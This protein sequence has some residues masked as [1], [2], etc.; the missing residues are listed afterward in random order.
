[1]IFL[2]VNFL[3]LLF[4][5]ISFVFNISCIRFLWLG[6]L[7][8]WRF[9]IFFV[10][11]VKYGMC[12]MGFKWKIFFIWWKKGNMVMV[13]IYIGILNIVKIFFI[14]LGFGLV[15]KFVWSLKLVLRIMLNVNWLKI[16]EMF[17]F[18]FGI[19][20][21]YVVIFLW[22]GLWGIC[23]FVGFIINIFFFVS[24]CCE[25]SVYEFIC[26]MLI[27]VI[28]GVFKLMIKK[29]KVSWCVLR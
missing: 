18:L 12:W 25:F 23:W 10:S 2:L 5:V 21:I 22:I 13:W 4:L 27:L 7:F 20:E 6:S 29:W 26:I 3:I 28:Y 19:K 11:F 16:L 8:F 24:F 15:W 9:S 17:I 1:M 14:S